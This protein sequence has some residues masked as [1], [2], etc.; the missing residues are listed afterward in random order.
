M[1]ADALRE[2]SGRFNGI[3]CGSCK[4]CHRHRLYDTRGNVGPCSNPE[5]L[6]HRISQILDRYEPAPPEV[7]ERIRKRCEAAI[8]NRD[9]APAST[10]ESDDDDQPA[11]DGFH[12]EQCETTF[13]TEPHATEDGYWLCGPCWKGLQ[14]ELK[15]HSCTRAFPCR[16]R[17]ARQCARDT[18]LG[19][20]CPKV[21]ECACHAPASPA[22]LRDE[23]EEFARQVVGTVFDNTVAS[24]ETLKQTV[25]E[26][27]ADSVTPPST[28]ARKAAEEI[29]DWNER[30]ETQGSHDADVAFI[31]AIIER[32]LSADGET[33]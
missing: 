15:A 20:E 27:I 7:L 3:D 29:Q 23:A 31:Q 30:G 9:V 26:R 6:S 25:I 21:C 10:V 12:C 8:R 18:M 13:F 19:S 2:L 24:P 11:H 4:V 28:L 17:D 32:C 22:A 1:V 14:S 33:R 5:C 16:Y